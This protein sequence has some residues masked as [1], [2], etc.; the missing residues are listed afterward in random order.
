MSLR[1]I[2]SNEI[3]NFPVRSAERLDRLYRQGDAFIF[4]IGFNSD[5]VFVNQSVENERV[6]TGQIHRLLNLLGLKGLMETQERQL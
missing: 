3:K 4:A 1:K 6:D 5:T 2:K